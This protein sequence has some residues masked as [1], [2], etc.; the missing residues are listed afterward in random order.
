MLLDRN[1]NEVKRGNIILVNDT[2]F[3]AVMSSKYNELIFVKILSDDNKV[4]DMTTGLGVWVQKDTV[5]L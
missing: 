4:L 3:L 5:I 2:K 1:N